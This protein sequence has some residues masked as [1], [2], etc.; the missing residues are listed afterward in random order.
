MRDDEMETRIEQKDQLYIDLYT[1]KT[2]VVQ[3]QMQVS[4]SNMRCVCV[5]ETAEIWNTQ[6]A[7]VR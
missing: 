1:K 4:A 6:I 2:Q 5:T 7:I 3:R